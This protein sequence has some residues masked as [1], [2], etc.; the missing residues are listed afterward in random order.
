MQTKFD[1]VD[2]LGKLNDGVLTLVSIEHDDV[3]YE[4]TFYYTKEMLALTVDKLLEEKLEC[5][6]EDWSGYRELMLN[7][8]ERVVPYEEIIVRIDDFDPTPMLDKSNSDMKLADP[9]DES[10]V[11]KAD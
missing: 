10:E 8:I 9:V 4:A 6:I 7:I 11:K 3:W 1:I 2:Y 5:Q